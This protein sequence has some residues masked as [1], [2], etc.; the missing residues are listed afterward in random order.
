MKPGTVVHL[1][2]RIVTRGGGVIAT[3]DLDKN[4]S[5]SVLVLAKLPTP[6]QLKRVNEILAS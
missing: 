5:V 6:D 3:Y 4:Q 2:K 1:V